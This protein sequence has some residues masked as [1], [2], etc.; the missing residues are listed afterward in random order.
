MST[1][2]PEQQKRGRGRPSVTDPT[3][4][5]K[6]DLDAVRM[7]LDGVSCPEIARLYG[8][9]RQAVWRFC[10]RWRDKVEADRSAAPSVT[11]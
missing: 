2:E 3:H 8:V 5:A 11:R 9:S 10:V 7:Y 1:E 4:L 6:L